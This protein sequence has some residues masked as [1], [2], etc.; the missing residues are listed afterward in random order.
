MDFF[1]DSANVDEIKKACQWGIINGVTTNPSLMAAQGGRTV[2]E[3]ISE[4]TSLVDGPV[5]AE[6]IATEAQDMIRE[7]EAFANI[8]K[9][10]TVKLPMTEEGVKA[11]K[12]LSAKGIKTNVTLV[13]SPLQALIAAKNGATFISP[14]IGRLDDIGHSGIQLIEE[15]RVIFDNYKI[16][17]KILAASIRSPQH[18]R[19][20]AFAKADV[21]TCPYKVL[22]QGFKHPLTD[23]GLEQ[24]LKDSQG[25]PLF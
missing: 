5:S 17:T 6:V 3:I 25:V 13:F 22:S 2:A 4:I 23:R 11:L 12:H 15:V 20:A 1:I 14:F 7:G 21:A 8:H 9:N 10:V 19:D 18:L 24:F 16:K